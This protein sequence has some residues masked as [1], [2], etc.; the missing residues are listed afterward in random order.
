MRRG[1][2]SPV[3]DLVV[4]VVAAYNVEL[5]L[6]C[7]HVIVCHPLTNCKVTQNIVTNNYFLSREVGA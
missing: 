2:L 1:F 5:N 6:L 4:V 7:D 3:P